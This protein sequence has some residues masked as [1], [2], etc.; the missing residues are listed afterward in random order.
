MK[1]LYLMTK[2]SFQS[3]IAA[4]QSTDNFS[5]QRVFDSIDQ[6]ANQVKLLTFNERILQSIN[7]FYN[8]RTFN[9]QWVL[10]HRVFSRQEHAAMYVRNRDTAYH[11]SR[12]KARY[13]RTILI[14]IGLG[15]QRRPTGQQAANWQRRH[16]ADGGWPGLFCF[17][18]TDQQK[19]HAYKSEK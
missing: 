18:P 13:Y 19:Q 17:T 1:T 2:A 3:Q 4:N 5:N 11:Q 8:Q 14:F 15:V 6:S 10:V 16:G 12:L 9:L 7:L